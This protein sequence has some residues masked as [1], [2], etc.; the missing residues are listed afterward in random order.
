MRWVY[1][2]VSVWEVLSG[3]GTSRFLSGSG[4]NDSLDGVLHNVSELK[5]LDQIAD[6]QH[7]LTM[8]NDHDLRI[9]D[10][11]P[12]FDTD[13]IVRLVNIVHLLDTLI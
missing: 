10:H 11:T 2:L 4:R 9:P 8:S 13:L 1:S 7:L 5:S 6:H 12:V 3:M